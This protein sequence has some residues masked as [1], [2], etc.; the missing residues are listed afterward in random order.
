[1]SK[2][3]EK[4]TASIKPKRPASAKPQPKSSTPKKVVVPDADLNGPDAPVH[5]NRIWPD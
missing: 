1:M 2:L 3:E 4:L 5:P